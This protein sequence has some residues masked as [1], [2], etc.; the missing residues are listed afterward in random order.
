MQSYGP[1]TLGVIVLALCSI[2]VAAASTAKY[3]PPR[4][5][6]PRANPDV[7]FGQRAKDSR[8]CAFPWSK[9]KALNSELAP[10]QTGWAR[11]DH[12]TLTSITVTTASQD[13]F[14]EDRYF[15][16]SDRK[17]AKL[18]RTGH[19]INDPWASFTYLP[20][21]AGKLTLTVEAQAIVARMSKA[22]YETYFVDWDT[23]PTFSAMPFSELVDWTLRGTARLGCAK[24]PSPRLDSE[25]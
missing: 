6:E 15:F 8:W 23:Y 3:L 17:I 24:Q 4:Q 2:N 1:S 7:W 19:Y 22:E 21:R 25:D 20:N 11:Y 16:A 9:V 13:A 18:V 10:P 5:E 12:Q 14:V